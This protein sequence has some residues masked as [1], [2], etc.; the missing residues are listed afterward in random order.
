LRE[1]RDFQKHSKKVLEH[2]QRQYLENQKRRVFLAWEKHYKQWKIVKNRDDFE[3]A[4]K[5]EL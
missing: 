2:R 3:K 5:L 1:Y 4:V